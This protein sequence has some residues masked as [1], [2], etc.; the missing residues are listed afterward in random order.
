VF[1]PMRE[2]KSPL[3]PITSDNVS[4][5]KERPLKEITKWKPKLKKGGAGL[6]NISTLLWKEFSQAA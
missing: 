1:F 5:T 3:L 4:F 6:Q 2:G